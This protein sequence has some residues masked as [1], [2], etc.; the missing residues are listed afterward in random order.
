VRED[1]QRKRHVLALLTSR[2][3][4]ADDVSAIVHVAAG[5]SRAVRAVNRRSSDVAVVESRCP[6]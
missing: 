4:R 5:L 6:F 2:K 1:T 3:I